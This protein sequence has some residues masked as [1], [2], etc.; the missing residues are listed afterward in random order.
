LRKREMNKDYCKSYEDSWGESMKYRKLLR[1]LITIFL[2]VMMAQPAFAEENANTGA[3]SANSI[4]V[5]HQLVTLAQDQKSLNVNDTLIVVNNGEAAADITIKLPMGYQELQILSG[6]EG[7]NEKEG[8]LVVSG[9]APG[10]TQIA[11]SFI[12]ESF[13]EESPHFIV[14]QSFNNPI[15]TFFVLA[16]A[17]GLQ[18][19]SG[20]LNDWGVQQMGSMEYQMHGI[21]GIQVG[22]KAEYRVVVGSGGAPAAGTSEDNSAGGYVSQS[23]PEFHSPGHI[24]FWNQSPFSGMNPHLFLF[25][26]IVIPIGLIIYALFKRSQQSEEMTAQVDQEEELFQK[27]LKKQQILMNKIK[28]LE[29]QHM[30]GDVD[31]KTYNE[32]REIYKQKLVKVKA[33]LKDL[34]S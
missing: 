3:D 27:L 24:R 7:T 22:S 17:Q 14:S 25:L 1:V 31:D 32:L 6:P 29:K 8:A 28:D 33:K 5:R 13:S 4:K 10:E 2:V 12:M 16:P 26:V 21:E 11:L 9:L 15:E 34:T 18:I 23:S 20:D 19:I 30:G